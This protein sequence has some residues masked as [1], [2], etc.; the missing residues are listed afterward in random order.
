[1]YLTGLDPEH[2]R[3]LQR[4]VQRLLEHLERSSNLESAAERPAPRRAT[5][6][7]V[8]DHGFAASSMSEFYRRLPAVCHG[9]DRELNLTWKAMPWPAG[10]TPPSCWQPDDDAGAPRWPPCSTACPRSPAMES[11]GSWP[12]RN[13]S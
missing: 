5:V 1:V 7:V 10:G 13:R 2:S 4:A 3:G 12:H 6:C 8:S 9:D 11:I